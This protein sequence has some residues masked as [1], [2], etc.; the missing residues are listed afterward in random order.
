MI[1]VHELTKTFSNNHHEILAV[2]HLTF[3][4][5]AGE[6]FGLLGP[7]GAGKTTTVRMIL[8]LL[9]PTSGYAEVE[10]LRSSEF[11]D[12][13]KRRVGL[14]SA[15]AGLYQ[16][17]TSREVLL[18][19]ADL[20]GL[21][22]DRAEERLGQ[23]SELMDLRPFLDQ[24]CSTLSTGQRQRVQLARALIHDPPIMLLDEPTRGLDVFGSQAIFDYIGQLRQQGRAVIVTT[25]RLDEA[26][27]LCDRFG[28]MHRGRFVLE[29]TLDELRQKSGRETLVDMFIQFARAGDETSSFAVPDEAPRVD[30]AGAGGSR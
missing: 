19:F 1:S 9:T 16:W 17:L 27:R 23:L 10:G 11:P 20:Y 3:R 15:S 21:D 12:E 24:R 13:V 28:L 2:D 14:V 26:Q 18:F 5:S 29:G 4:V 30:S 22:P 8:G 6:V 25:H 7:N